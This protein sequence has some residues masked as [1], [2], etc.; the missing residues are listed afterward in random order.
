MTMTRFRVLH[1]G[2]LTWA[3]LSFFIALLRSG[4]GGLVL[5]STRSS[6]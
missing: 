3:T 6:P 2:L 1:V 4:T 5:P